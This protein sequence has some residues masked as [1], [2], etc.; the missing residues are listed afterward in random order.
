MNYYG[1]KKLK[2]Q[3]VLNGIKSNKVKNTSGVSSTNVMENQKDM[4]ALILTNPSK[5]YINE[6]PIKNRD[7]KKNQKKFLNE[8]VECKKLFFQIP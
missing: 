6:N 2:N 7:R 5:L 1:M 3:S 4:D 8:K